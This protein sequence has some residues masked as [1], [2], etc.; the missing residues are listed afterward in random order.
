MVSASGDMKL[1]V[2]VCD[3][4]GLVPPE[5]V[6]SCSLRLRLGMLQKE[7]KGSVISPKDVEFPISSTEKDVLVVTVKVPAQPPGPSS[8]SGASELQTLT[9]FVPCSHLRALDRQKR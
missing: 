2:G 1:I 3:A 9:I 8:G 7:F 4:S 6:P 5:R